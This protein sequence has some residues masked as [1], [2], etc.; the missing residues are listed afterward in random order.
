M[1][2]TRTDTDKKSIAIWAPPVCPASAGSVSAKLLV[3]LALWVLAPV[4]FGQAPAPRKVPV[5][6]SRK[7]WDAAPHNAFT[8]LV[9]FKDRWFCVFREGATHVSPD[10]KLLATA[11]QGSQTELALRRLMAKPA[12]ADRRR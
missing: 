3:L 11:E 5:L 8:D 4:S 12:R 9:R 2:T 10:G 7:I 6:E 1:S